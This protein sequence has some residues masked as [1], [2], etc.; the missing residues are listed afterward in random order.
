MLLRKKSP[1]QQCVLIP[2][3]RGEFMAQ[4]C[5]KED[6]V[7]FLVLLSVSCFPSSTPS[8]PPPV[9][10]EQNKQRVPIK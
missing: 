1:V 2:V 6:T 9:V 3:N 5:P 7:T 8:L 10:E 4:Q